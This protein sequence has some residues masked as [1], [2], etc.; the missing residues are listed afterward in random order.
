MKHKE[1]SGLNYL[2]E[3]MEDLDFFGNDEDDTM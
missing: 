3:G 1:R 2:P